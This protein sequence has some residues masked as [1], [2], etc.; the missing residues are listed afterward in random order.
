M[1]NLY[2]KCEIISTLYVIVD[3]SIELIIV[4]FFQLF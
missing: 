1:I 4:I 2:F 3:Y